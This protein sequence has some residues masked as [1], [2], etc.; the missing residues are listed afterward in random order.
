MFTKKRV[1]LLFLI[2]LLCVSVPIMA[3]FESRA[4]EEKEEPL[5]VLTLWQI[6][7]F[8]GGKGSRAQ[9]LVD[10]F[11]KLLKDDNAYLNV[12]PLTAEAA[13]ENLKNGTVPDMISCSPTFNAHLQLINAKDFAYKTWCYGSYCLLSLEENCN[14]DDANSGNPVINEGKGNLA[15]VAAVMRGLN[16]CAFETPTSAYLKLLNGKYKYLLGTQ[17]DV[18]R[19]KTRG[20]SFSVRQITEFNDLYQNISIIT[21]EGNRYGTCKRFAEYITTDN[22][23]VNKIGMFATNAEKYDD[24]L[25]FLQTAGFEYSLQSPCSGEYISALKAAAQNCD[26]NKIKNLLK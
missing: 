15:A 21:R 7:G 20:V 18:Y 22:H 6:D 11:K 24:E 9:Y 12:I 23:D 5:Q 17:R 26:V 25:S 3:A 19:L 4:D 2:V 14:F 8:E 13:E 16:G 1:V 10:K